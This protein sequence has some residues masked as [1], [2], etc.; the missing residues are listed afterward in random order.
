MSST[1]FKKLS[2]WQKSKDL[3][4]DIYRTTNTGKLAKDYG[5]RE[6]M[7]RAAVSIPSN[8]A[9]GNDRES[10]KELIY[11][12]HIAKGSLSELRTQ[13]EIAKEINYINE[14]TYSE[15]DIK[16]IEVSKMLGGLIKALK[17]KSSN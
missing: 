17:N 1:D 14:E 4:V 10:E 5:L 8:I 12:L 11:Y 15:M 3:A 13:L 7:Q 9:E 16:C 2:V 6:Q